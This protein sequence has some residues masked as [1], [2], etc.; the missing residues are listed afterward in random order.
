MNN[1]IENKSALEYLSGVP[2]NTVDLVLTDPPYVISKDTGFSS[3]VN[4]VQRFAVSMDFGE[5]DKD[6]A[7]TKNDLRDVIKEYYRVLRN[8]GTMIL[9]YDLWK[10]QDLAEICAEV[11]FKQPR[12]IEWIKTNPVPLNSKINYLTNSREVAICVT[13]GSKPTFNSSYDNGIYSYPICHERGRFH[14]T[15]KPEAFMRDLIR[16][17]TR[18][19]DTVLDCFSGSGT[20]V[21]AAIKEGRIGMGCEKNP[22]FAAKAAQRVMEAKDE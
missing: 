16:K 14:P 15:Q 5:W 20:T 18:E 4:G 6:E 17:H 7:F 2:S 12:M 21:V 11:G 9:F 3:V 13:K 22:E 10:L 8:G 19:G 1:T